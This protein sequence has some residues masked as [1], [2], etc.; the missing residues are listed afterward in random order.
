MAKVLR[1]QFCGEAIATS[2]YLLNISPTKA[3]LNQI[4]YEAL[5]GKKPHVSHFKVFSCIAYGLVNSHSKLDKNYEKCIFICYSSQ[6]KV[7]CLYNP[8]SGKVIISRD[9]ITTT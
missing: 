6:S 8:I 7:Y 4:P 3:M 2:A 5:M 9:V 1:N